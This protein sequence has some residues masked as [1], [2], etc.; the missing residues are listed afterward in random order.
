MLPL[1]KENIQRTELAYFVKDL[2]P[3]AKKL[4]MRAEQFSSQKQHIQ[5]KILDNLQNQVSSIFLLLLLL[6]VVESKKFDYSFNF[7][8]II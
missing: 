2:L 7:Y 4:R 1:L 5:A 6:I 8:Y 3:L